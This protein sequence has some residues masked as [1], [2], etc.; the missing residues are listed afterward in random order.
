MAFPLWGHTRWSMRA[1]GATRRRGRRIYGKIPPVRLGAFIRSP[2]A[3][4]LCPFLSAKEIAVGAPP[5]SP[6]LDTEASTNVAFS[7]VRGDVKAFDV[8]IDLAGTVS[9]CVQVAFGRD[10]DGDGDLAPGETGLVLGWRAGRYL[11]EDVAAGARL[12]EMNCGPAGV[13]RFLHLRVETDADS[14][15]RAASL[16][17]EVGAC[18]PDL[19]SECP[20]WLFRRD[21]DLLQVARRGVGPADEL[22]RVRN[23]CRSLHL[24]FR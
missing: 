18:F 10:A 20:A 9:N 14:A 4:C 24:V 21:W 7:L 5:R 3:V 17:N 16:A 12:F 8:R 13:D 11:V 1:C 6:F 2:L 23:G 19:A 22:C 15:P